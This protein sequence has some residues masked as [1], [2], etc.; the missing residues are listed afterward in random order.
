VDD[1]PR[2]LL[3]AGRPLARRALRAIFSEASDIVVVGEAPDADQAV[4]AAYE[5][6][7][8]VV[9]VD[10]VDALAATRLLVRRWRDNPLGILLLADE[11]DERIREALEI[12]AKALVPTKSTPAELVAAARM[13]A[14]G[15]SLLMPSLSDNDMGN[16]MGSGMGSGMD[17]DM[18]NGMRNDMHMDM[19]E[20]ALVRFVGGRQARRLDVLTQR[21]R[22]VLRLVAQGYSNSDIAES[23]SLCASTVK[24]HVGSMLSK[25]GVRSRV[26]AVVL[27]YQVGVVGTGRD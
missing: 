18:H 12:G 27:A 14:A 16:G 1:L 4:A 7:P 2:I 19:V 10:T 25:L 26:Q 20:E 15:Y 24:S 21:E 5:F 13:V 11:A 17:N 3:V 22:D 8:N 6:E 9:V 23:L